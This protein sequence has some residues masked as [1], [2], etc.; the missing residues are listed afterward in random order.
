MDYQEASETVVRHVNEALDAG[1]GGKIRPEPLGFGQDNC[2]DDLIGP[3][4]KVQP[5][6]SYS[7]PYSDLGID[8]ATFAD[9]ATA[10]WREKGMTITELD[11]SRILRRFAVSED[12]FRFSL[13]INQDIDQI[14]IGGSGPCVDPPEE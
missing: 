2:T 3:T 4:G 5:N 7:F 8:A 11:R 6:L 1:L 13:T 10:T 9:K 14:S 12:G